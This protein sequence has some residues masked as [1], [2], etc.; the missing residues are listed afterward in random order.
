MESGA[1]PDSRITASSYWIIVNNP[2]NDEHAPYHGRLNEVAGIYVGAWVANYDNVGEWL[3]VDLGET[4]R[5]SGVIVQGRQY[6]YVQWVTSYQLRYRTDGGSW[7]TYADIHGQQTIFSGITNTRTPVTNLLDNPI[8]ARYVRFVAYSWI[9]WI[10]MR[11]EILGCNYQGSQ[12]RTRNSCC[13]PS[14]ET[15]SVNC[16]ECSWSSWSSWSTCSGGSQSRRRYRGT[17]CDR[18]HDETQT[19]PCNTNTCEW[20]TWQSWTSC[21]TSCGEGRQT[22]ARYRGQSCNPMH[23][24]DTRTCYNNC[25]GTS[26]TN[27]GWTTSFW[28]IERVTL[29]TL[30]VLIG[31]VISGVLF[32]YCC[33]R[34]PDRVHRINY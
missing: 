3:Q 18:P 19:Q 14:I 8:R 7:R 4:K 33:I 21:S 24:E 2:S 31:I 30:G 26:N 28:N 29:V 25:D 32:W 12:T 17:C 22:R 6:A 5:V 11:V 20:G 13:S 27:G 16:W 15:R 9:N 1:I 23:E 10:S 34:D